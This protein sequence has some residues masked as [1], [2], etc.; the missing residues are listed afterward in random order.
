[1]RVTEIKSVDYVSCTPTAPMHL[2]WLNPLGGMDTWVFSRH[3]E[4]SADVSD[5]DEFEPVV[6][7]LQMTNAR[8]RTLRKDVLTVVK[9]GYEG[10]NTQQVVGI[11]Y[12]LGSPLVYL[13]DGSN[14][15]QVVVKAGTFK[16]YDTGDSKHK[17]EFDIILPKEFTQSL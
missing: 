13:V 11:R 6:N 1:M 10:L 17:L 9:L 12:V 14:F 7:Y 15:V 5:V 4:Y 16:Y 8:Q 3:Q 2:M